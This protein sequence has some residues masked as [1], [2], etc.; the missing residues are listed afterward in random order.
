[1][2]V[3]LPALFCLAASSLGFSGCKKDAPAFVKP[4]D[5]TLERQRIFR[6]EIET[7]TPA[8]IVGSGAT[9]KVLENL[10]AEH[11]L[12][13]YAPEKEAQ[14]C[15][16][17][18]SG[19]PGSYTVSGY[20]RVRFVND[21]IAVRLEPFQVGVQLRD[22]RRLELD[23]RNARMTP[24]GEMPSDG[25]LGKDLRFEA[26]GGFAIAQ[27]D[28]RLS[29]DLTAVWNGNKDPSAPEAQ[30]V[31][32]PDGLV[33]GVVR[34]HFDEPV[35][36]ESLPERFF[37]RDATRQPI[38]IDVIPTKTDL[39]EMSTEFVM[40]PRSLLPFGARLSVAISSELID[41]LGRRLDK[42]ALATFDTAAAPPAML[43]TE[44]DFS[45]A[46]GTA[47]F[48]VVGAVDFIGN[49]GT[50]VPSS[51]QL[52]RLIP[53][54]PLAANASALVTRISVPGDASR[55]E[56]RVRKVART[57]DAETPCL[58]VT[59]ARTS[60]VLWQVVCG[61][62]EVPR[63][64]F[65]GPDGEWLGTAWTDVTIPLDGQRNVEAIVVIE[66]KARSVTMT[67]TMDTQFLVDR[68]RIVRGL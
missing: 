19:S 32:P 47:E 13:I 30:I 51:G 55:L 40:K 23:I 63:T 31:T 67:S 9:G 62:S 46:R 37:L 43:G 20:T 2:R 33:T 66:A 22:G 4:P 7:A 54:S 3:L 41:L 8:K 53:P 61:A 18:F 12:I 11:G 59:L 28:T 27:G 21:P 60:G 17:G 49:F 29:G 36:T 5:P 25:V 56:V 58:T 39:D 50:E 68:I 57:R 44:H 45:A 48:Q 10:L 1:M 14:T 65:P 38:E 34:V 15:W 64:A 16:I 26:Q 52:A 42:A 24:V 35:R 6:L